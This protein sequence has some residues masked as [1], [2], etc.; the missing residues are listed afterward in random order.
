MREDSRVMNPTFEDRK[1]P[2]LLLFAIV[3][4]SYSNT[5]G[6]SWQ[7]DDF[8]N[9]LWNQS[10]RI[11]NLGPDTLFRTFF[12]SPT[13]EGKLY[14][15]I[16][17]LSFALNW[18]VGGDNVF[19]YHL[20]NILIHVLSA[21]LLYLT[22]LNL[23]KTPK[24]KDTEPNSAFF[25]AVLSSA[26]WAVHPVQTQ[27]VTYIVQRM[28][29]MAAFF[30]LLSL[31]CYLKARLSSGSLSRFVFGVLSLLSFFAAVGSKENAAA[32][33]L[34]LILLEIAFFR[35]LSEPKTRKLFVNSFVVCSAMAI[36]A[37]WLCISAEE[38]IR[39]FDGYANRTFTIRERL[40]TEPRV[41]IFYLSQIFYPISS[42]F[43]IEHDFAISKSLLSPWTTVPSIL[44][45]FALV[46][47][48][49]VRINKKPVSSFA[50]LFYFS[51]HIIE[52]TI[53]P[54]EIVFEHRNY[55]PSLFL[56]VPIAEG[57]YC[58][59][60][61]YRNK[62]AFI[63]FLIVF[64]ITAL[65]ICLGL[66]TRTRNLAWSSG[67]SL[68]A[69]ALEK[70]PN[71]NRALHNLAFFHYESKGDYK[72][73]K[74]YYEKALLSKNNP[75][76]S[77]LAVTRNNLAAL[78]LKTG[79]YEKAIL[80]YRQSLEEYPGLWHTYLGL[81]KA[82]VRLKDWEKA[83]P[84]LEAAIENHDRRNSANYNARGLAYLKLGEGEKALQDFRNSLRIHPLKKE[85]L[86]YIGAYFA[87][88]QNYSRSLWFFK[89]AA[90]FYP[91]DPFT[92]M[93]LSALHF[94]KGEKESSEREFVVFVGLVG[95]ENIADYLSEQYGK[96]EVLMPEFDGFNAYIRKGITEK[97][98]KLS[99]S[100]EKW[101]RTEDL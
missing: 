47:V 71:S 61:H 78:Y 13:E 46:A 54:L 16:P 48:A 81:A 15:P 88:A 10:I 12:A 100:V 8:P 84:L 97:S 57:G 3:L 51:N 19:G 65:L 39:I 7:L 25:V 96:P 58:L 77:A 80:I 101:D 1:F 26:I 79:E 94:Q 28:A 69:S 50:I 91:D 9:I 18:Y 27:A 45:I 75:H 52:S 20:V 29:S 70:V 2:F 56:F 11:D 36:L 72:T 98:Q 63:G 24:L 53:I 83:L 68:W 66:G 14:R 92:R 90:S 73:A 64:S 30:Y 17:C 76:V 44:A 22:V 93:W 5:F 34:A 42:R 87:M 35:D 31:F 62:N 55:L 67:R 38:K 23:Y 33:P 4:L 86:N 99:E 6:N 85:T 60:N 49:V 82:H 59:I 40:M 95:L 37:G 89:I 32:L 21:F 41:I 74:E 43:S